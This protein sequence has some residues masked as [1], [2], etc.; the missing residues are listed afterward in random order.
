VVVGWEIEGWVL[1]GADGFHIIGGKYE[2]TTGTYGHNRDQGVRIHRMGLG[3]C[4]ELHTILHGD[5]S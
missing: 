2:V 3:K 5:D 1:D 4:M